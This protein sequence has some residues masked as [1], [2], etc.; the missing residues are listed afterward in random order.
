MDGSDKQ[1]SGRQGDGGAGPG[2]SVYVVS[3]GDGGRSRCRSHVGMKAGQS[4]SWH[5]AKGLRVGTR[6]FGCKTAPGRKCGSVVWLI[7]LL[8]SGVRMR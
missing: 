4:A 8:S 7:R 6:A 2:G 5:D 3:R 1:E